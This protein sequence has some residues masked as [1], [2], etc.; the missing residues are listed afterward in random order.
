M[1]KHSLKIKIFKRNNLFIFKHL[2]FKSFEELIE[3][4]VKDGALMLTG[5]G[6]VMRMTLPG[7]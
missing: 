6:L 4:V 5:Y 3:K 2:H 1:E 7:Q